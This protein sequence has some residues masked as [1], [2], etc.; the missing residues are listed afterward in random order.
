[1][2]SQC[3]EPSLQAHVAIYFSPTRALDCASY[4]CAGLRIVT[5]RVD[6]Q[7]RQ[8]SLL[9]GHQIVVKFDCSD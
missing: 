4:A 9:R 5:L 7:Q 2:H 8:G 3:P 1:V 6:L